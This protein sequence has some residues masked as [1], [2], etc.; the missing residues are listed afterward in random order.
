[1]VQNQVFR[2]AQNFVQDGTPNRLILLHGP[3]GSA[4]TTFISCLGRALEDYS[5]HEVGALYR[6][7][8]IFPAQ[9]STKSG[10]G[11][12]G[13]DGADPAD[14]FAYLPDE[15]IDARLTDELRDHPLL[16]IP[17]PKRE[18]MVKAFL[19]TNAPSFV[20]SDYL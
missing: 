14:T 4:K 16:L 8:W 6:F 9:K 7:N 20:I 11:F 12:G 15:L 1:A 19:A 17:Q 13:K 2:I 3:N 5:N 18:E 10:I